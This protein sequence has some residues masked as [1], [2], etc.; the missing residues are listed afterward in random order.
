M[1]AHWWAGLHGGGGGQLGLLSYVFYLSLNLRSGPV[2]TPNMDL[3][4]GHWTSLF[5]FPIWPC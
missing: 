4:Q 5:L 1:M 3:A 2:K